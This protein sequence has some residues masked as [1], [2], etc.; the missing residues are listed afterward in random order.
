MVNECLLSMGVAIGMVAVAVN[1]SCSFTICMGSCCCAGSVGLATA[2][3]CSSVHVVEDE[4]KLSG[5]EERILENEEN[6]ER[7][8]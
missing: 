3:C 5:R 7:K 8:E 4:S 2:D 1:W 6:E